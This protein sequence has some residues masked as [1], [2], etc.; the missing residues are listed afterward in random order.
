MADKFEKLA[1]RLGKLRA[2]KD[3]TLNYSMCGLFSGDAADLQSAVRAE[4]VKEADAALEE[5]LAEPQRCYVLFLGC[6]A[7]RE[8]TIEGAVGA[9]NAIP[10]LDESRLTWLAEA[11]A[12][13]PLGQ[14]LLLDTNNGA[15]ACVLVADPRWLKGV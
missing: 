6:S 5:F 15:G 10:D 9:A 11:L 2:I 12:V 13:A 1:A 14:V 7:E 4:V 3:E 8:D